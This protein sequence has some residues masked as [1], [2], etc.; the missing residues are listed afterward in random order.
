MHGQALFAALTVFL[1]AFAGATALYRALFGGPRIGVD[2]LLEP[3]LDHSRSI[4]LLRGAMNPGALG[5]RLEFIV[6]RFTRRT[7]LSP[8]LRRLGMVLGY[9]GFT[10]P[11]AVIIFRAVQVLSVTLCA[12]AG[13]GA[14]SFFGRYTLQG[15]L[16]FAA[17]GY[18]LPL[19]L[20][21]R[22]ARNRQTLMVREMPAVLDLLL[23]SL[24]SGLGLAEALRLVARQSDRPGAV[25]G[26]ELGIT[27][28]EMSAGVPLRDSLRNLAE[29]NGLDDIKS[30]VALLIQS[31]EM[32]S[33]VASALRASISQF[34][35]RRRLRAE[36]RAQK[37]AVKMLV[38]LVLLILPAMLIVVL[39]PAFLQV[40]ATISK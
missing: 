39:G 36:E 34:S 15:A 35:A 30:V 14:G 24:E 9:A 8:R 38:P 6:G 23:V 1:L 27:A 3:G 18:M 40:V 33:S 19:R 32:G 16:L 26:A 2:R 11:D 4:S 13:V 17:F 25:L 28:A 7:N 31:D 29:R 5:D 21:A 37:A 12:L 22:I 10:R 20:L